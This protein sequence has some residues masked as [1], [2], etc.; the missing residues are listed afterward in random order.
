MKCLYA[1]TEPHS[2]LPGYVNVSEGEEGVRISVRSPGHQY[3]SDLLLSKEQ[4]TALANAILASSDD[5]TIQAGPN[6]KKPR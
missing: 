5:V 3:A 1:W 2:P 6:P 4:A